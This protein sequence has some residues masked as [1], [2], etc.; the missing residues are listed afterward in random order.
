MMAE[1]VQ[2]RTFPPPVDNTLFTP[3][4]VQTMRRNYASQI[5]N[6][7]R[8]IGVLLEYLASDNQLNNTIIVI[9]SD[10]GE[11]L[12]DHN[13]VGKTKPWQGSISVP[14]IFSGA[15]IV[16]NKTVEYPVS[17]LDLAATFLELAG[18]PNT[19]PKGATSV[20][21]LPVLTEQGDV[22]P[23]REYIYSGL[24]N[25]RT[26]T[27]YYNDTTT[28]KLIWCDGPCPGDPF[29]NQRKQSYKM[30]FSEVLKHQK[31]I[32]LHLFNIKEDPYDTRDLVDG[33]PEV[34]TSLFKVLPNCTTC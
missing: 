20:S 27:Q 4:E 25:F 7:D 21:L 8:W 1:E 32:T 28:W 31:N 26:V 14:L 2:N 13:D 9:T 17:T 30:S 33:F 6:V 29:V 5:E 16:S 34:V 24:A 15:G 3:I 11:M 22:K 23:T 18:I 10:H 19:L 12:G